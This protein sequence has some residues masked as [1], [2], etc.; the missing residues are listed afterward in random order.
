MTAMGEKKKLERK[1]NV[2]SASSDIAPSKTRQPPNKSRMA[3]K[4]WLLSS[5]RGVS[6]A[7]VRASAML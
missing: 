1:K 7:E 3:T 2:M 6:F 4:N 5:S